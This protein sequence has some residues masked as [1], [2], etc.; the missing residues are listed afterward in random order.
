[1]YHISFLRQLWPDEP[2]WMTVD[3][4]SAYRRIHL[5][6]A[7][8]MKSCTSIDD[9]LLVALRMTFGGAPNPSQ[10]SDVSEMITDLANDLVRR[11]DWDPSVYHSPHQHLLDTEGAVD[12]DKG[13]VD[14]MSVFGKAD[15]FAVNYPPYD[16]LPRFD[17]YLDDIFGAFNP[18]DAEK[19]AAAIPLALHLVGRPCD[20]EVK[21]TF[22]RDDILAIPKFLAE[23]KPSERK[24]ILGWI[25]DTRRFVVALPHDKHMS[26][27]QAVDRMLT[28]RHA[29]V[30]TRDL[31]TTLGRFSHAAYVIPYARH[32]MGRLYKA[33]ERSKQAGKARLTKPQLDD[34]ILWKAFLQ[35]A[36]R[37]ISINRLVCRWPTRIVRVDAC[38]QGIGGYCLKSGLA[39]RYQLPEHLLGRATLNTLEFLAAFVGMIVEFHEGAAW[40]DEDVLLSQETAPQ[41]RDGLLSRTSTTILA[42]LRKI[43]RTNRRSREGAFLQGLGRE[44]KAET[45]ACFA[46]ALRDGRLRSRQ[47]Q[48]AGNGPLSGSIR[49][50]LDGVAQAFRLNKFESPIHDA[51]GRLDPLLALQLKRYADEDPGP[52]PQQALPLEVIRKVRSWARN[53]TDIAIGQLVVVAF[54]FAMRSCEYSDVGSRRTTSVIRVDDVRFR[55]KGQDLQTTDRGQLENADTVSI[56]FRRQKNGDKGATVTQHRN[57]R[58]GQTDICPVRVLADLTTRVRSYDCHSRTNPKINAVRTQDSDEPQHISSKSILRQLRM[59]TTL[60][61][62]ERLGLQASG[63]GTHSI[64]SGAAMAMHLAGVPSETIQMVGRWRSQTFMRYLRIQVPD[65]T[66]GV[67]ARMTSRQSFYTIAPDSADERQPENGGN[68]VDSQSRDGPPLDNYHG[69]DTARRTRERDKTIRTRFRCHLFI[70]T[71]LTSTKEKRE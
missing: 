15:Y 32:F 3:C 47:P 61:G 59:A 1:M 17:C 4:K 14:K 36:S 33:C 54:F 65:S 62:E 31:E 39:W 53:E 9:L 38:P 70:S 40:T 10:W 29:F 27:T 19:S 63:I 56:T 37:G 69:T 49:A 58:Q 12:N 7:T 41:Q 55:Q 2:I 21:E 52:T 46:A 57:D 51:A 64:R 16:D 67:A 45:F 18:R 71:S 35:K 48:E 28:H 60:A 22:P 6:A 43:P 13:S 8:A 44:A 25:V 11:D 68:Q 5:K 20:P 50:T 23:A 24:M 66:L 42:L 30:T 34:L 26:W